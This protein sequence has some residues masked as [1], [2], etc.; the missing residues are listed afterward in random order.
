MSHTNHFTRQ[1]AYLLCITPL[2]AC[3]VSDLKWTE[4]IRLPDGRVLVL[5]RWVEF[6]GGSSHLGDPSVESSQQFEFKHPDTG[7]IVKWQN[8]SEQ[9]NL[10]TIALW[11]EHGRPFLLGTP[12]YGGDS[13]KYNC[14]NPPYLLYEYAG[15]QWQT[16]PLA[17]ISLKQIRA[18]LTFA[19]LE[20]R[21]D[22][23]RN[24]RHL[25]VEQ[26]SNSYAAADGVHFVPYVIRF[27]GMPPQTF[28]EE[29][30]SRSSN[31]N[32]LLSIGE[33]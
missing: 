7:A 25:G 23:L 3:G 14:P 19:P 10:R 11:L 5:F 12:A 15:G 22:I 16:K 17:Q 27:E 18:N 8:R 33:L 13:R 30:C 31:L 1:I 4:D 2:M 6:E 28:R 29:D 32:Y 21:S 9:G 20:R 24:G 26:T